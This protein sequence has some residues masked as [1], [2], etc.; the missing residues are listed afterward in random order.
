M[1]LN[2]YENNF[3]LIDHTVF[4]IDHLVVIIVR[5]GQATEQLS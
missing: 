3:H 5:G 2:G 4:M 1:Y